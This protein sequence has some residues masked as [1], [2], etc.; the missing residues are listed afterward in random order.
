MIILCLA[1]KPI[2]Y[3]QYHVLPK[4]KYESNL[5]VA[6]HQKILPS[7]TLQI[8]GVFCIDID[9]GSLINKRIGK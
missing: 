4:M 2:K 5:K 1:C 9:Q 8:G 6:H 7:P 3:K